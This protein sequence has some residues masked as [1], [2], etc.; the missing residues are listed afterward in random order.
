VNPHDANGTHPPV[1]QVALHPDVQADPVCPYCG[2]GVPRAAGRVGDVG[3]RCPACKGLLDELSI[4]ATRGHMGDWFVRDEASPFR[5]GCSVATLR[6]LI[7]RGRVLPTS[8]VRGPDTEQFWHRAGHVPRIAR[9]MGMCHECGLHVAPDAGECASCGTHLMTLHDAMTETSWHGGG[10]AVTAH[11]G[12]ALAA[13]IA[14]GAPKSLAA[15][16]ADTTVK[17]QMQREVQMWA[18]RAGLS[19]GIAGVLFLVVIALATKGMWWAQIRGGG[20]GDVGGG[21]GVAQSTGAARAPV[22]PVAPAPIAPAPAVTPAA[23]D[24]SDT[25]DSADAPSTPTPAVEPQ[26]KAPAPPTGAGR[27]PLWDQVRPLLIADTDESLKQAME[28]LQRIIDT[29]GVA[30]AE[31]H[32]QA[33]ATRDWIERRLQTRELNLL[34]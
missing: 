26:E 31:E 34:P 24:A 32:A 28:L 14:N 2:G 6:T 20:G 13:A 19:I 25:S 4:H 29:V 11:A 22:A 1:E 23:P 9:M 10:H 27:D 3:T 21:G 18:R 16:L 30:R 15:E 8:V 12:N 33:I 7:E 17:R 5:P